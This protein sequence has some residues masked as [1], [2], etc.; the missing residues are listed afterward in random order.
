MPRLF[1]VSRSRFK[2]SP[3]TASAKR[4]HWLEAEFSRWTKDGFPWNGAFQSAKEIKSYFS[5]ENIQC[6]LCG[7]LYKEITS[8]HLRVHSTNVDEYKLRYGIPKHRGLI[9]ASLKERKRQIGLEIGIK[10]IKPGFTKEMNEKAKKAYRPRG[11]L[12]TH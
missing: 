6:L 5:D 4:S 12:N 1:K 10:Y 3:T 8:G 2:A 7:K 9:G 11:S